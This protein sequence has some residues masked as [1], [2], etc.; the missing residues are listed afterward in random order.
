MK[1]PVREETPCPGFDFA[2]FAS[3]PNDLWSRSKRPEHTS[4]ASS[5]VS[6]VVDQT[7]S[8]PGLNTF[9]I[10][11][12]GSGIGESVVVHLGEN[13]W[14]VVDSF[15]NPDSKEPVSLEYLKRIEVSPENIQLIVVS[16]WHDDH[17]K[18]I[19]NVFDQAIN[20]E[21]VL[22]SAVQQGE[23]KDLIAGAQHQ[24]K[25]ESATEEIWEII[26]SRADRNRLKKLHLASDN[27]R[28]YFRNDTHPFEVWSLSPSSV[29]VAYALQQIARFL[30][31]EG[32]EPPGRIPGSTPN[33]ASVVIWI[34]SGNQVAVLGGDLENEKDDA[35]G[36]KAIVASQARPKEK[37]TY[38]KIPHHGSKNAYEKSVWETMLTPNPW[39]VLTP[40][41][42]SRLP[43]PEGISLLK[44]HTNSLWTAAPVQSPPKPKRSRVVER[45]IKMTVRKRWVQE[46]AVGQVRYR[47]D[48][49]DS[50]TEPEIECF[51]PA[52][53]L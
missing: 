12:F 44:Q 40:M 7:Y 50:K 26:R 46:G 22:S 33:Q 41:R 11:V 3:G 15:L 10:S 21:I 32:E 49:S 42:S 38:F 24:P 8:H 16:H 52:M 34:K 25:C 9:E 30:P 23:L 1:M 14:M 13:R 43:T 37:A 18:G 45:Q 51:P 28:I 48:L 6:S 17:I 29:A 53:R 4:I 27:K 35:V 2:V 19:A 36:W 47:A 39:T 31:R 5:T 20:A